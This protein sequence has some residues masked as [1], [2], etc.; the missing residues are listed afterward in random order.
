MPPENPQVPT[1]RQTLVSSLT[2]LYPFYSGCA[3]FGNN[4]FVQKLA[5]ATNET[6]WARVSGGK[7]LAP[8]GDFV[9]RAAYYVGDYDRQITWICSRLIRPG[10]TV[11]DIGANIGVVTVWMAKLVGDSGR[12][13]AFEPNPMLVQLL[14]RVIDRNQLANVR[15]HPVALGQETGELELRVPRCNNAG[16]GSLT[17]Y[18]DSPDCDAVLVS[19]KQLSAVAT[20]EAIQSVRLIKIDVEGYEV[21][22]FRGAHSFLQTARPEAII[23]ELN[24]RTDGTDWES[25]LIKLLLE[26]DYAILA[27]PRAFMR[28]RLQIV[29]PRGG[30]PLVGHDFLAVARGENYNDILTRVNGTQ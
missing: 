5:G 12:V 9:G 21:E 29:D 18:H 17:R 14:G 10:D 20:Q 27:I 16:L 7:I 4:P 28:M 11:L 19:V 30:R 26:H 13:H 24:E 23:F 1:L 25:P 22:V 2:R 3:R 15:L 8:L 6:V